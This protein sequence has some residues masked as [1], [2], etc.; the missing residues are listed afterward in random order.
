MVLALLGLMFLAIRA[1]L[2]MA[3]IAAAIYSVSLLVLEIDANS[4]LGTAVVGGIDSF[5]AWAGLVPIDFFLIVVIGAIF[6]WVFG[7]FM[8]GWK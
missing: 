6:L 3:W 7:R 4:K 5:L 2:I 8:K 1:I